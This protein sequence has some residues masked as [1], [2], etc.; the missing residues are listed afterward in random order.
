M[1]ISQKA[2]EAHRQWKGKLEVVSVP[3]LE[4]AADLAIAYTPGVAAP[5]LEIEKNPADSYVYTGRGNTIAVISDGTAVLGLGNIGPLAGMPVMEGKCVLFR[6]LGGVNAI[7]LVIDAKDTEELIRVIQTLE[8]SFGG[9]NLEDIAAPRCF[10][11]EKRLQETMNIPVFHDDQHG[12]ACTVLAALINALKLTSKK[13]EEARV[14]FSG[15]GAAGCAI[16]DLLWQDGFRHITLCDLQGIVAPDNAA[17]PMQK[18]LANRMNPQ[19][20]H[21]TLADAMKGAD[22]FIGVSRANLVSEEMVSSMN[23][24]AIV[25]AMAN[26]VP[27]IMPELAKKAGARVVGCGRSDFANQINNV[28]IFPGLFRGALDAGALKITEGMKLAAARALAGLISEDQLRDDYVIVDALDPRV[29][30]AVGQAVKEA[31]VAEGVVRHG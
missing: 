2:L 29:R 21:G 20:I 14:V 9:I 13:K 17:N 15:A 28:L 26:P 25:F 5:C 30:D 7:P 18:E 24:D 3:H 6:E 27:E 1:D 8:P 22:I 10:E 23:D 12:T 16:A 19:G 11:V 4:T 31:A